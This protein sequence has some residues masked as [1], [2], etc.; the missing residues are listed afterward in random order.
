MVNADGKADGKIVEALRASVKEAERL[1]AKN[2][3][4]LAASHEP[5]AIVGMA[6]RYPGGVTSPEDL[7]QLVAEGRDA[8]GGFPVDRGWDLGSLVDPIG[9]Q[10]GT[11]YVDQGGFLATPGAFDTVFFGIGP[12]EAI[13]MDPQQR[14]LLE[15]TWEALERAEIDPASLKGSKTGVYVGMMYHDYPYS[16]AA[17]AVASGRL[18]YWYGLEGPSLTVDTACSSSLAALH[19]ATQ[20]LRSGECTMALVGGVAVMAQPDVFVEFSR[21]KALSKDGRCRS[22][23]AAADGTS[24][25]EGVG[26]IVVERLS[27][28]EHAGHTV[29]AVVRG[30]AVNQDGA[31]NGLTA[32]SGPSQ[33]R[34]IRQALANARVAA[35]QVDVVEAH[36]TGT[37]LGD[38]IE[39]QAL[40][41]TYGQN[42]PA[43][44]PL[45]LGSLKSNIGHSQA[46]AGVGGI[47]KMVM[48]LRHGVL[49]KTL[50]V[51]EPTPHVDWSAGQVKLLTEAREW[52]KAD[53]PRRA[54][55]SSFGVSGTNAHIVLEEAPASAPPEPASPLAAVPLLL[56]AKS[57][58]GI[59][60]QA[61]Q[62]LTYVDDHADVTPEEVA[63]ALMR[64]PAL[65]HRAVVVGE[66]RERLRTSLAALAAEEPTTTVV[67]G[68]AARGGG[69]VWVF[70]GQGSQWLG[71]GAELLESSPVFGQVVADCDEVLADL[72]GWSAADVLRD[73]TGAPSLER[74]DVVQP[75]LFVM[76]AGLAAVWR[77]LGVTP[78]VVVG[79]SQ[80]EVAAAYVAGGL[81]LADALRVVVL[82]S[83]AVLGIAGTGGMISVPL[84]AGEL[85]DLGP[86]VSVAALNGAASVVLSGPD[87]DLEKLLSAY[88]DAGVRARR[89]PVD[90]AS[91]SVA[92][93]RLRDEILQALESIRP[94]ASGVPF[95]ST[96]TGELMDT[97]GLDAAYWFRNLRETVRFEPVLRL[98]ADRGHRTFVEVS[99]HPV[100]TV[101]IRETLDEARVV[102]SLRRNEG[103]MSR[104]LL[105]AGELHTGGVDVDWPALFGGAPP[106]PAQI[107]TY[108]FDRQQFWLTEGP[109]GDDPSALGLLPVEHNF[110]RAAGSVGSADLVVL[111]GRVSASRQAW[112]NDHAALD[113]LL[114]PGTALVDLALCA[115]DQTGC[116]TIEELALR[117]P[118]LLPPDG[119]LALQ[120]V[121]S[122][123]DDAGRRGVGLYS[124]AANGPA[125]QPWTHHAEGVLGSEAPAVPGDLRTWPPADAQRIEVDGVYDRLRDEGYGYGPAFQGL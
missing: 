102:G 53:H 111:R 13:R 116:Q 22:F 25:A 124:R 113:T 12:N 29:L 69:L 52:P 26:M 16:N 114:L 85:G 47:I 115:A 42:R 91:H 55:V 108:A 107:P 109:S 67:R 57:A 68:R 64:R 33:Q 71:M 43:D 80:G 93:D 49:P 104:V 40:L 7:W 106:R 97:A 78:D 105:S 5:L 54:A 74:V 122:A 62:L 48:A 110:L 120:V 95:Y 23:A 101:S 19:L 86:D 82:R 27:D 11:T 6:C 10:P 44:R 14:L 50:H 15:T 46:A 87:G 112:V 81:S 121:V 45:W 37:T 99:P 65:E 89:I 17:G 30:T 28:A 117:A 76:M 59:R 119:D 75:V 79:H 63:Y 96:V 125:D 51:D 123:P 31:S 60:A 92:V 72:A 98:L 88:A 90:Y 1:R 34:V 118:L 66:D 24:W 36:G 18:S 8:I 3:E 100:I 32:P 70:P 39:A 58:D 56:S 61:S 77:S 84:P 73:V 2:R 83:R 20:A 4:L 21:Q 41:A 103:G 94:V 9:E 38:P 35:D